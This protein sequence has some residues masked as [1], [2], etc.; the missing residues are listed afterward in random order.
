MKGFNNGEKKEIWNF[1]KEEFETKLLL[2]F[3]NRGLETVRYEHPTLITE[4]AMQR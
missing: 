1:N 2:V 4:V 3:S